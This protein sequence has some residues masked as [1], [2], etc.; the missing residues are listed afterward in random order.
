[1]KVAGFLW[2]SWEA[3]IHSAE[4]ATLEI[5]A[6][7]MSPMN[8]SVVGHSVLYPRNSELMSVPR[9]SVPDAAKVAVCAPPSFH[10]LTSLPS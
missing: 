6:S 8:T 9:L 7:S 1:M 10:I 3:A 5:R 2:F 4:R